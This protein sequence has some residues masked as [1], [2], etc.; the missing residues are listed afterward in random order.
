MVC[1]C[2]RVCAQEVA[3][4]FNVRG[5][6]TFLFLRGGQLVDTVVGGDPRALEAAIVQ[7]SSGG[8][9]S[10]G[11]AADSGPACVVPGMVR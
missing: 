9:P 3:A 2:V 10:S 7:L 1:G 8:A 4:A 6:P 11:E 5:F